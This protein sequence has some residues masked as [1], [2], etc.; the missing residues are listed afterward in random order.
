MS[1]LR[2][3]YKHGVRFDEGYYTATHLPLV[4]SV[5]GPHGVQ[6]VEMVK[7]TGTPSSA[8][9]T[10]QIQFSAYFDSAASLQNALRDPRLQEVLADI[11][12]FYDGTPDV[13]IGEVVTLPAPA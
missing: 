12:N 5:M 11:Q 4:G 13:M 2:V 8:A 3:G 1:V 6:R 9:P 10:Y 7:L